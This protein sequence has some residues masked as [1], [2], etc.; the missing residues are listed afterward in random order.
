M[1]FCVSAVG[2]SVNA[3]KWSLHVTLAIYAI[4]RT[5]MAIIWVM[6]GNTVIPSAE[7]IK[8]DITSNT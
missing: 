7:I 1:F 6:V 3:K 8:Q 5:V 4:P 2:T